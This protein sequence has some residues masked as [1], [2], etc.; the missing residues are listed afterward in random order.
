MVP[1]GPGRRTVIPVNVKAHGG[2]LFLAVMHV[3]VR[4]APRA[5]FLPDFCKSAKS[6]AL[7]DLSVKSGRGRTRP[8]IDELARGAA[9]G[10]GSAAG[11]GKP[12]RLV[13]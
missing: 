12:R 5:S 1:Q 6:V 2:P 4:A 11:A 3:G 10:G 7:R 8:R 9:S 13:L